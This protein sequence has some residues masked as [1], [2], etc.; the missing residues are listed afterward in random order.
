VLDDLNSHF[1]DIV[2][3]GAFEAIETTS[4]ERRDDDHVDLH[5]VAFEFNRRHFARLR[6]LINYLNRP[7][8]TS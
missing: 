5:R 2:A 8:I 3:T 7:E 1:A 4:V 6:Q